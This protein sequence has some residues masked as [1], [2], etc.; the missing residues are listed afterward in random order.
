MMSVDVEIS[1]VGPRDGLQGLKAFVPTS[2]KTAWI[3]AEAAAGVREIEVCSFVPAKV[4][5]QFTD[6]REVVAH[7]LSVPGLTVAAL[8][9]NLRGAE[10]AVAAG[11]HKITF[12]LSASRS[13]SLANVRRTPE[14][15]LAEFARIVAFVRG[16]PKERRPF[17]SAGLSTV[18]GCVYEGA[19]DE[20]AV[21][22][23]A[24]A[25][26][27][28]GADDVSLADTTGSAH[29]LQVR[30][31]VA[32]VKAEIG[33]TL[34]ALH[35]HDTRGLGLANVLAGL[36]AGI[37]AFD[38]ALGG[39]GG[40]PFAPGA[41]GNIVTEDLV[42]MLEAMGL[43]TGIDLDRLVAARRE[44]AAALPGER[45]VGHLHHAGVPKGFRPPSASIP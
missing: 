24:S 34:T 14:E 44:L 6:A 10:D 1:E 19:V 30:R 42:Y 25:L 35:L 41:L 15:Q 39:L 22:R 45:F 37:R 16:L 17:L 12:T 43:R 36:D 18:F 9:P 28:A 20:G 2:V 4:V 7:A 31:V 27:E 5:P 32:V 26:A 23:L 11:V 40:C 8:V 3:T 21:R 13:H 33:D 38:A 29:P